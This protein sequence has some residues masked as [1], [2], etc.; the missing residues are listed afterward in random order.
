MA[1]LT[2][3]P[4]GSS[5]CLGHLTAGLE[6]RQIIASLEPGKYIALYTFKCFIRYAYRFYLNLEG[7]HIIISLAPKQNKISLNR[8]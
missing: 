3:V 6:L 1:F 4:E 2:C 5:T 8:P 7:L